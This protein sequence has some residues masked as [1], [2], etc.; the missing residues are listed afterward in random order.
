[1]KALLCDAFD[2]FIYILDQYLQTLGLDVEVVRTNHVSP[3][4]VRASNPDFLLLGP[5]PGHPADVGYVPLIREFEGALP[6]LGV[7][8]G[9]QAIGL[10]YGG[11]VDVALRPRHG[12]MSPISHDGRGCFAG[13]SSPATVARYHSLVVTMDS[14]PE[15]LEVSAVSEDDDNVMGLR[16]KTLPI[17]GLQFHPESIATESGLDYLRGFLDM[18]VRR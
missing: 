13:R 16:H 5:G 4:R 3:A 11:K 9:H 6:I 15:C 10:A 17:E 14:V 1:M 18:H 12:K 2:S 7:C 8:L